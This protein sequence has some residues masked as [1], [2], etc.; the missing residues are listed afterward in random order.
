MAGSFYRKVGFV[1]CARLCGD[2]TAKK[3][4]VEELFV[5]IFL[6]EQPVESKYIYIDLYR[7][8][9]EPCKDLNG[10]VA[11]DAHTNSQ[12]SDP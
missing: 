11:N 4:D 3:Q 7:D 1:A 8:Q 2:E 12:G 9:R 10:H 5:L 6:A